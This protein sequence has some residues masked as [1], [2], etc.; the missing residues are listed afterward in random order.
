MTEALP[1]DVDECLWFE[2]DG[3]AGRH[4]FVDGNPTILGRM[5]AYCPGKKIVTRVSKGEVRACSDEARYFIRGFLA[6]S[7]PGP[8]VDG[9]GLL[10]DDAAAVDGW[11]AATERWRRTGE[12]VEPK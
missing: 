4:Y 10:T 7:E 11:R 3:C 9:E 8:P 12:W 5:Y 2:M 1:D 6:G